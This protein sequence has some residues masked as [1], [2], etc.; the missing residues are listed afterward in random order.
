MSILCLRRRL[1]RI[2]TM[3]HL[4]CRS[5]EART[6]VAICMHHSFSAVSAPYMS[7]IKSIG[8]DEFQLAVKLKCDVDIVEC[9]KDSSEWAEWGYHAF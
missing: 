8:V 3:I 7:L 5:H 9:H 6:H 1:Y 2:V 4:S